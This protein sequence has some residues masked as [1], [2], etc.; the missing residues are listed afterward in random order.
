M[1]IAY[2]GSKFYGWQIQVQ[3]PTVQESLEQALSTIAKE[4]I[5]VIGAGRTDSGV[6]ASFQ[7]AHFDF[8]VNMTVEQLKLAL[9]GKL[10]HS[11]QVLEIQE[12][13]T[14]FHARF[15]ALERTYHYFITF[16]QTPFNY[17]YK[18]SFHRYHINLDAFR[19]CIPYFTGKRDFT[20]FA[21]PN[22][23]IKNH[24]CNVMNLEIM[25]K[26]DDLIIT[27]TAN[28]FLHNMVRRIV[29][30]MVAVSHKSLNPNVIAEW[31]DSK[32]HNQ[33]NYFTAPPNGLFLSSIIYPVEK[34]SFT[35]QNQ[36]DITE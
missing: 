16:K 19:S 17:Y 14:D 24:E 6:H 2:D 35:K 13:S 22:P 32:K 4:Q 30:A 25:Q 12:V 21:K 7:V 1:L 10:S 26:M 36:I 5:K 23:E 27:I 29:G 11:V 8:P 34:L 9:R 33:K 15:D 20:S 28:R 3:S 31:I 18:T